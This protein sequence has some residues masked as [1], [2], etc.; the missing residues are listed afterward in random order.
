MKKIQC[1]KASRA[2]LQR[3]YHFKKLYGVTHYYKSRGRVVPTIWLCND[4]G[5]L[6]AKSVKK[7]DAF[8]RW[9][10]GIHVRSIEKKRPVVAVE[11][12][13]TS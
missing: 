6:T 4:C 2:W 10:K 12:N 7:L 5:G 13:L 3:N 1:L 11:H 8:C 9:C